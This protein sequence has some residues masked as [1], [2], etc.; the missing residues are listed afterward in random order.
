MMEIAPLARELFPVMTMHQLER[1]EKIFKQ[2][3]NCKAA[4]KILK[5]ID[6]EKYYRQNFSAR[7]RDIN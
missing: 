4:Q 6:K 7:K 1:I 3:Q 2:Q 5:D